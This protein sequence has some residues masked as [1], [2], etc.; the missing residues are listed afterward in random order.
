VTLSRTY[1]RET[2]R[3]AS[4]AGYSQLA[5]ASAGRPHGSIVDEYL[6]PAWATAPATA[7]GFRH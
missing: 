4:L 5:A 1:T 7:Q 2:V 3:I 6:W